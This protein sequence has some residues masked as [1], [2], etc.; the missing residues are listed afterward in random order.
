[1]TKMCK[2]EAIIKPMKLHEVKDA[3]EEAGYPSLT[4]TDVKGRG[5]QK[6]IVQQWRGK[7]YCVDLLPKTKI[8]I[9]APEEKIEDIVKIIQRSAYTGEIGDGKIFVTPIETVV[10]IR[11]GERDGDAL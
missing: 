3:L 5:Q 9:A 1:M 7:K 8:E 10:R 6:G 4:V 11:T 2:I